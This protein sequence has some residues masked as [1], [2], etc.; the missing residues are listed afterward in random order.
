MKMKINNSKCTIRTLIKVK[1][2]QIN[3]RILK[4]IKIIKKGNDQNDVSEGH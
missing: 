2:L 1:Q 4:K 3:N